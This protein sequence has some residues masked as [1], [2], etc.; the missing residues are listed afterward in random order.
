MMAIKIICIFAFII[1]TF[2][3]IHLAETKESLETI[4][5][6]KYMPSKVKKE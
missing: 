3:H 2:A 4:L 5:L 6:S 1:K